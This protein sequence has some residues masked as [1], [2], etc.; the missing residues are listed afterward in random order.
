[1]LPIFLKWIIIKELLFLMLNKDILFIGPLHK[2]SY[3][4]VTIAFITKK[5]FIYDF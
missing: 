1:L 3:C 5:I 4:P 2:F